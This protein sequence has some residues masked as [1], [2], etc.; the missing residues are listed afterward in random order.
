MTRGRDEGSWREEVGRPLLSLYPSLRLRT[1][2]RQGRGGERERS[3]LLACGD[4]V[5][6][7]GEEREERERERESVS[8]ARKSPFRDAADPI[9]LPPPLSDGL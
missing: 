9:P 1:C 7:G 6:S 4:R 5:E 2:S 3:S 8:Q